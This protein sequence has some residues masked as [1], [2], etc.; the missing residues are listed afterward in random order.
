MS[1]LET[2]KLEALHIWKKFTLQNRFREKSAKRAFEDVLA[3][4]TAHDIALDLGANIGEFTHK[5][6]AT[7]AQV[8]AIEPD[9]HAFALLEKAVGHFPNVTLI[10][11]AASSKDGETTL[12]RSGAFEKSPDR[13]TKSSSV[14]SEKKNVSQASGFKVKTIDFCRFLNA[15]DAP[16]TLM[17]VDIEGAEVPLFEQI[18]EQGLQEHLR[19][20][21][22][23]T[24]E[25]DIPEI[26]TRTKALKQYSSMFSKPKINWDWH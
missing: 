4:L 23:E 6:A 16:V 14:F 12:Y 10:N 15:L 22:V 7:G 5:L 24:H 21:F 11:A 20:V 25:R 19:Y 18:F 1:G 3:S 13:L 8:Y 26:A 9:P 17:K 2:L